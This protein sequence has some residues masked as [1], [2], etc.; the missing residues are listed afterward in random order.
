M[1]DWQIFTIIFL[2]CPRDSSLPKPLE[3]I[4]GQIQTCPA[5]MISVPSGFEKCTGQMTVNICKRK[6]KAVGPSGISGSY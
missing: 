2:A 3:I 6:K 5:E 1:K 4:V